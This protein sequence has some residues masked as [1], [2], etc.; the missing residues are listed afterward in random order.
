[1]KCKAKAIVDAEPRLQY[2]G[3][4]VDENIARVASLATALELHAVQLHGNEDTDYMN[5]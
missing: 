2:V 4:F 1:M 5:S 3:V